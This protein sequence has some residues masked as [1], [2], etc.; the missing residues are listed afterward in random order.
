[1]S[2]TGESILLGAREALA[3]ARGERE[4][5]VA[6]VPQHV[7]VKIIRKR[8]GLSQAKF[9]VRFG[10]ALD[11]VRNWEQGRRQPDLAARAF[12]RVIEREPDA[13][14]RALSVPGDEKSPA[15]RRRRPARGAAVA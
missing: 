10:F 15:R 6:H 7:D 3:Y 14:R 1:M 9:A 2:K 11:A 8:L 13:V 12:L 5:F 4:G